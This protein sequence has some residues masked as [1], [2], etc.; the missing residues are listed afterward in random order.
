MRGAAPRWPATAVLRSWSMV[1]TGSMAAAIF[2]ETCRLGNSEYTQAF[3]MGN[4]VG[5]RL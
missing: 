4:W 3:L 5:P 2:Q 1:P